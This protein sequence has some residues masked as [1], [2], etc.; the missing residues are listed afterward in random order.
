MVGTNY[1]PKTGKDEETMRMELKN[2]GK[3]L[4]DVETYKQVQTKYCV[5]C[6]AGVC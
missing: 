6:K 4:D 2:M 5:F 3:R 1:C